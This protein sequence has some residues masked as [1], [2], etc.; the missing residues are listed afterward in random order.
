MVFLEKKRKTSQSRSQTELQK[1][2]FVVLKTHAEEEH[3]L[4]MEILKEK[5]LLQRELYAFKMKNGE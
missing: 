3:Q 4:K 1:D 5:R 2:L